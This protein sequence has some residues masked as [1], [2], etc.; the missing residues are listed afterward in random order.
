VNSDQ[1]EILWLGSCAQLAKLAVHDC[2]LQIGSESIQPASAVR[3]LGVQFD[4]ELTMKPHIA[5][6]ISTCFYYLRRLRQIRRRVGEDVAVRLILALVTPRLDYCNSSLAGLPKS[7]LEPL[8]AGTECSSSAHF[9]ARTERPRDAKFD[10]AP[11][12]AGSFKS[13]V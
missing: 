2:S 13:A 3:F 7:T 11:L 6:T 12:A 1:T 5:R 10:S 9:P 8:H 4:P